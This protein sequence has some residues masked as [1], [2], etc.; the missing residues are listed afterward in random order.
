VDS[1]PRGNVIS[2]GLLAPIQHPAECAKLINNPS[3]MPTAIEEILRWSSPITHIAGCDARDRVRGKR[4]R[5][6]D[7]LA[8]WLPSGNRDEQ[9]FDPYRFDI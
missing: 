2:G 3:V 1:R 8:L 5:E 9:T 4:I 6:G 7:W